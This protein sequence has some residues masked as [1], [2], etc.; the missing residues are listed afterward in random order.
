M[1]L[2]NWL[3]A[4][5]FWNAAFEAFW[6]GRTLGKALFHLR[7]LTVEGRPIGR[8]QALLRNIIRSADLALGPFVAF[9]LM[10]ND[11]MARLGDLAA[12]TL[13]VAEDSQVEK[14][15]A[16]VF[17]DPDILAVASKIPQDFEVSDSLRKA[18]AL[19]VARRARLSPARRLEIAAPLCAALIEKIGLGDR[20]NPD[21][22]MCALYQ[23]SN[24]E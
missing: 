16:L 8:G 3:F 7:V 10:T 17:R 4:F 6:N 18:L 24:N 12:G 15:D 1:I 5:W 9:I 14:R 19:Y 11:R 23:H 22:F 21:V 20:V 2:L 13:V